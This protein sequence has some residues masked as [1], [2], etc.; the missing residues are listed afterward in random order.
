MAFQMKAK[1]AVKKKAVHK[2]PVKKTVKHTKPIRKAK[3][4]KAVKKVIKK[5][6]KELK[7][8]AKTKKTVTQEQKKVQKPQRRESKEDINYVEVTVKCA[9]CGKE[10]RI[11]TLE[12]SDNSE[13]LCQKCSSGEF[14]E[15][16]D[17]A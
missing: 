4:V 2:K 17:E 14:L 11:V 15:E 9:E 12:G 8:I 1:K 10:V 7:S 16:D 13:Y 6:K 5:Q 3:P